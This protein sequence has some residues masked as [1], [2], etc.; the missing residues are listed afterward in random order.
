MTQPKQFEE[1][2]VREMRTVLSGDKRHPSKP[3][4]AQ[5][6][7]T[8]LAKAMYAFCRVIVADADQ[9]QQDYGSENLTQFGPEGV[10]V[11]WA[12][13]LSRL[14]TLYGSGRSPA[15]KQ[16]SA[17]DTWRDGIVYDI[18]GYLME[19]GLWPLSV[20]KRGEW[21]PVVPRRLV[22][23]QQAG[24]IAVAQVYGAAEGPVPIRH[25]RALA[26]QDIWSMIE[27]TYDVVHQTAS[28]AERE[29]L[30]KL[31]FEYRSKNRAPGTIRVI[32]VAPNYT[33][34]MTHAVTC[35]MYHDLHPEAHQSVPLQLP[36]H[37]CIVTLE[38]FNDHYEPVP[39]QPLH[40]LD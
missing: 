4:F 2:V 36:D 34:D 32:A 18:I 19:A 20:G 37:L 10:M 27:Q 22:N 30:P 7:K 33:E 5:K 28:R 3:S 13:K 15:V 11:R 12:D 6:L 26:V 38:W 31:G 9:K 17:A 29:E 35:V 25:T 8:D 23:A 16:E 24:K 1:R 21:L 39:S 14:R 40:V